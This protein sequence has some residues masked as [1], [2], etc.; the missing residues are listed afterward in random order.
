MYFS[1]TFEVDSQCTVVR[2]KS[3]NEVI[4][5]ALGITELQVALSSAFMFFSE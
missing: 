4:Y 1:K 3:G 5:F 2:L